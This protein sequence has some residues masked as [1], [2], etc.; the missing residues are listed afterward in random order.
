MRRQLVDYLGSMIY[1]HDLASV[2]RLW[3]EPGVVGLAGMFLFLSYI[4]IPD[5]I[6]VRPIFSRSRI[7]TMQLGLAHGREKRFLQYILGLAHEGEWQGG[8][9]NMK[10]RALI[11]DLTDRH[12]QFLGMRREYMEYF[13]G[14]IALSVFR[15]YAAD[16][17]HVDDV[18]RMQCWRY[19]QHTVSFLGV[20]L[21]AE[22]AVQ[23][24]CQQF[25]EQFSR[26]SQSGKVLLDTLCA[27]Y[28]D[29]VQRSL[30]VLFPRTRS[31]VHQL[32]EI[33]YV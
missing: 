22:S 9:R 20:T 14:V 15:V 18:T 12:I 4:T 13:A 33:R 23:D 17:Q 21:A 30:P 16:G 6:A 25:I 26:P 24:Y 19:M 11:T 8:I 28:P 3:S 32:M 1:E 2:S 27:I 5:L 29:Y 31:V 10:V 7:Y